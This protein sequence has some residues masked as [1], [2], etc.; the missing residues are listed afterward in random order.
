MVRLRLPEQEHQ[1]MFTNGYRLVQR[2][3]GMHKISELLINAGMATEAPVNKASKTISASTRTMRRVE[4][5]HEAI[6]ARDD[7]EQTIG[8]S[9][10]PFVLCGL[11]VKRPPKNVLVHVRHNGQ[12]CLRIVG[13]P[14]YGLPF[15]QDRLIPIWL[16]TTAT[17]IQSK[18]IRFSAGAEILDTFGLQKDGKTYRRLID[19]FW[20]VFQ[21]K[22][23]FG[24]AEVH[25]R[26]KR[27]SAEDLRYIRRMA[28]WECSN[29]DQQQLPGDDFQNTIELSDEFWQEIQEHPIP[30]DLTVVRALSDSPGALDFYM[31]LVY[32]CWKAQ[33]V[34]R[35][36]LFG[37]D[38]LISQLGVAG[39]KHRFK[40]RQQIRKWL[41]RART[42]WPACPAR[43]SE[44]GDYLLIDHA[45]AIAPAQANPPRLIKAERG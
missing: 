1:Q 29:V 34:H 15:G 11:P 37:Q 40:F 18:F 4:A 5:V 33:Q 30:C 41:E 8:Y 28:L 31:W 25:G 21:S 32:R 22:V 44:D 2:T 9:S 26:A 14:E 35:I 6:R 24:T 7:N 43:L 42:F 17:R 3:H 23:T 45:A 20:R 19:G 10:R 36:P 12:L 39:Y 16:A 27:R 38:G 13:D